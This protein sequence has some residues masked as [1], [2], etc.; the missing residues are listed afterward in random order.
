[1][2]G[3]ELWPVSQY[4]CMALSCAVPK[5]VDPEQRRQ[6]LAEA[7]FAVIGVRGIEAVSLRDV[8]EQAGVSLGAVQH[9]FPSKDAML[10]FALGHMRTRVML[11]LQAAIADLPSPSRRDAIRAGLSA[12]LPF[13][14]PGRQEAA[15]SIAFFSSATHTPAYADVLREGFARIL[16]ASR[17]QLRAAAEAGELRPGTDPDIEAESLYFLAQGLAAPVLLGL[18]TPTQAL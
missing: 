17:T 8:A 14:E 6:A 11:R 16:A 18:Y 7:V 4:I 1:M 9:Y 2:Y 3:K 13:D 5:R 12:M 10:L 15:V